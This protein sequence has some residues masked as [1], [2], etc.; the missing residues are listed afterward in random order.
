[1]RKMILLLL[2]V[3]TLTA[4][5]SKRAWYD[6]LQSGH[7]YQCGNLEGDAREKCL[8][9]GDMSYDKYQENLK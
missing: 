7:N 9:K 2:T 3:L 5:C 4:G 6:G 8:Q 1:M